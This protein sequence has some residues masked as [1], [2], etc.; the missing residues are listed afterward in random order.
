M[1]VVLYRVCTHIHVSMCIYILKS[2]VFFGHPP[3]YIWDRAFHWLWGSVIQLDWLASELSGSVSLRCPQTWTLVQEHAAMPGLSR[4]CWESDLQSSCLQADSIESFP[5]PLLHS[6]YQLNTI[7]LYG[8]TWDIPF[9][10]LIV[11]WHL[12]YFWVWCY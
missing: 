6:F 3:A 4:K 9:I 10:H 2:Y 1:C 8:S 7:P 11:D 5:K 12:G